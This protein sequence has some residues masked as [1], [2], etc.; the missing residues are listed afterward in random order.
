MK[1]T[2]TNFEAWL[3]SKNPRTK[4]GY[5]DLSKGPLIRFA[6]QYNVNLTNV[7]V[8]AER[9]NSVLLKRRGFSVSAGAALTILQQV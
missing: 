4:V 3:R 2:K 6:D 8:W 7:P 5:R 9:F 1:F